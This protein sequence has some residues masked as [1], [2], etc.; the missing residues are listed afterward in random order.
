MSDSTSYAEVSISG[1]LA[2]D[3]DVRTKKS[4]EL[5]ATMPVATNRVKDGHDVADFHR[6]VVHGEEAKN[7][8]KLQKGDKVIIKGRLE[9]RSFEGVNGDKMYR[10]EIIA[11]EILAIII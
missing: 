2:A 9:N 1:H 8:Q 10:T 4:G 3:V 5:L 6:I 11:D 7:C